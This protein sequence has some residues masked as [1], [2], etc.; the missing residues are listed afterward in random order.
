[1]SDNKPDYRSLSD[2]LS[3]IIEDL[4]SNELDIDKVLVEYQRGVEVIAEL[5]K[6]LNQAENKVKKVDPKSS[7]KKT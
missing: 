7:Q 4:Q 3:Q 1:M 6:Y 2:E 5:E